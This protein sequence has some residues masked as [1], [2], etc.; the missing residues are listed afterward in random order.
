MSKPYQP[1][2]IG[3]LEKGFVLGLAYVGALFIAYTISEHAS[4]L[5]DLKARV[6]RLEKLHPISI[7]TGPI[8]TRHFDHDHEGSGD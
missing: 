8:G 2:K 5:R 4:T 1:F 7:L 3:P 6:E